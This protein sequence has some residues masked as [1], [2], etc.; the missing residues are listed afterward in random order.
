MLYV[1]TCLWDP[2]DKSESFSRCYDE[3][4]ADKL[5]RA[6]KRN[7]SVEFVPVVFTDRDRN[8]DFPGVCQIPLRSEDL[9][10]GCLIEPFRIGEP[11]IICG[12]DTVVLGNVD[13][14]ADYCLSG[15]QLALPRNPYDSSQSINAIALVP[16]G[17]EHIYDSWSGE[18]DMAWLRKFPC[19][20][21]DDKWPGHV[22]SLKAHDVRRLGTQSARVIYFHGNPKPHEL[23]HLDWVRENW[24]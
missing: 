22:L 23:M 16:R 24:K 4:W 18:N 11:N 20:F 3:T 9:H 13:H 1:T 6:F 2:N 17:H 7:L 12:L 14:F 8:F 15:D 5:F 10:Y 21:I 19:Q